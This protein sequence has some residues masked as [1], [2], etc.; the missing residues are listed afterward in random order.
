MTDRGPNVSI[1]P[2]T[3]RI[4]IINILTGLPVQN[5]AT[6][7]KLFARHK[8]DYGFLLPIS[9]ENGQIEITKDWLND[10]I[11]KEMNLFVMDYA[12]SLGTCYPKFELRI[13]DNEEIKRAIRA[14]NLYKSVLGTKQEDIDD[15][16]HVDNP[17]YHPISKL[18]ELHG[19]KSIEIELKIKEIK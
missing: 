12:S 6:M 7:I 13:L 14:M 11:E 5:I 18:T 1:F 9:D 19:E 4:K 10:K 2:D 15:L 17:K 8:N 3:I 16:S